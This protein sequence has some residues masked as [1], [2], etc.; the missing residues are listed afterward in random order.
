MAQ[1]KSPNGGYI[2]TLED[3]YGQG[4][5]KARDVFVQ[6]QG[7]MGKPL[8][9]S[10]DLINAVKVS[11]MQAANVSLRFAG[12]RLPN[13]VPRFPPIK[14]DIVRR[15]EEFLLRFLCGEDRKLQLES[16]MY[17]LFYDHLNTYH[18]LLLKVIEE[19]KRSLDPVRKRRTGTI[20]EVGHPLN[21]LPKLKEQQ[22]DLQEHMTKLQKLK[23]MFPLQDGL[24]RMLEKRVSERRAKLSGVSPFMLQQ[25][26]RYNALKKSDNASATT[27][28]VVYGGTL[29]ITFAPDPVGNGKR[30]SGPG[31]CGSGEERVFSSYYWEQKGN[32]LLHCQDVKLSSTDV[33]VFRAAIRTKTPVPMKGIADAK[34]VFGRI[35]MRSIYGDRLMKKWLVAYSFIGPLS[36]ALYPR[37]AQ[38]K[39]AATRHPLM[40]RFEGLQTE[41][42]LLVTG[43]KNNKNQNL[44]M[45]LGNKKQNQN[46]QNQNNVVKSA[47]RMQWKHK[48]RSFGANGPQSYWVQLMR[49]MYDA[50]R[51][52]NVR[53]AIKA[54]IAI[55]ARRNNNKKKGSHGYYIDIL[56]KTGLPMNLGVTEYGYRCQDATNP[57]SDYVK[58]YHRFGRSWFAGDVSS[59]KLQLPFGVYRDQCH[60]P[61][62]PVKMTAS[63]AALRPSNR[64]NESTLATVAARQAGLK[65]ELR[66]IVLNQI[67]TIVL[68]PHKGNRGEYGHVRTDDFYSRSPESAYERMRQLRQYDMMK[69]DGVLFRGGGS[70]TSTRSMEHSF[71]NGSVKV[72][73][74]LTLREQVLRARGAIELSRNNANTEL[75]RKVERGEVS[76]HQQPVAEVSDY[77]TVVAKMAEPKDLSYGY[78]Y[79]RTNTNNTKNAKNPKNAPAQGATATQATQPPAP[80]QATATQTTATQTTA[81]QTTATQ[82]TATQTTSNNQRNEKN[83]KKAQLSNKDTEDNAEILNDRLVIVDGDIFTAVGGQ[84]STALFA[85]SAK[86]LGL[87]KMYTQVKQGG[88]D[89]FKLLAPTRLPTDNVNDPESWGRARD[90][91]SEYFNLMHRDAVGDVTGLVDR[92]KQYVLQPLLESGELV[93]ADHYNDLMQRFLAVTKTNKNN[94]M[95]AEPHSIEA[96]YDNEHTFEMMQCLSYHLYKHIGVSTTEALDL[97]HRFDMIRATRRGREMIYLHATKLRMLGN[98]GPLPFPYFKRVIQQYFRTEVPRDDKAMMQVHA[99]VDQ[100]KRD[101]GKFRLFGIG[102]KL[103]RFGGPSFVPGSRA[104]NRERAKTTGMG[105]PKLQLSPAAVNVTPRGRFGVGKYTKAGN[106]VR[107]LNVGGFFH[108]R[109]ARKARTTARGAQNRQTKINRAQIGNRK[110]LTKLNTDLTQKLRPKDRM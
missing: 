1:Y 64:K 80:K 31:F 10:G 79:K 26:G 100:L 101:L 40:K 74:G 36:A 77:E 11:H 30:S 47:I 96:L 58:S 45:T 17:R 106:A 92:L 67:A 51:I 43:N 21:R 2:K 33:G 6:E 98:T 14:N 49:E 107:R 29:N 27:P 41:N 78:A 103:A 97:L 104:W 109:D 73:P 60:P 93:H 102:P 76:I 65:G 95:G 54:R 28:A 32:K 7:Y 18:Q 4:R 34:Q 81:T 55:R 86:L 20:Y 22:K 91:A 83:S 57:Q 46:N 87:T 59:D 72:L 61:N 48:L 15:F 108:D 94:A 42:D 53:A 68:D 16:P 89:Q 5:R 8:N 82:T 50:I 88:K 105:T 110:Q 56:N 70:I 39:N 71:V 85:G 19:S 44:K 66:D 12:P 84:D 38:E 13:N 75:Q 35:P 37:F 90:R 23:K 63:R 52:N 25:A 3:Y 9:I 99:E 62:V 69:E 24:I